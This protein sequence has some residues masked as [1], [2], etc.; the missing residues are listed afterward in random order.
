METLKI[1]NDRLL[2]IVKSID[3]QV[4]TSNMEANSFDYSVDAENKDGSCAVVFSAS[5]VF[6]SYYVGASYTNPCEGG[7]ENIETEIYGIEVWMGE[8]QLE[9]TPQQK[10]LVRDELTLTYNYKLG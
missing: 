2:E 4:D 9:L 5:S 10:E 7:V 3:Y 8:E 1:Q 6:D